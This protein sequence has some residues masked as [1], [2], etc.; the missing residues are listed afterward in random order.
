MVLKL[1][2]LEDGLEEEDGLEDGLEE[3]DGSEAL[4][5]DVEEMVEEMV[6]EVT[7]DAIVKRKLRKL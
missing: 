6:E 5:V 4:E 2:G 3:E 7:K 1:T